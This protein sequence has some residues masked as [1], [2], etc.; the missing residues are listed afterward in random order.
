MFVYVFQDA[1]ARGRTILVITYVFIT[2]ARELRVQHSWLSALIPP[3]DEQLVVSRPQRIVML[4][5]VLLA[6][7]FISALFLGTNPGMHSPVLACRS[8]LHMCEAW[9]HRIIL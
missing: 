9:M 5:V 1:Q 4:C 6:N 3:L 2:W 8:F 7:M